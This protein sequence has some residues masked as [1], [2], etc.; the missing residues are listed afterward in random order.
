M[1][2]TSSEW[3]REYDVPNVPNASRMRHKQM[4][5]CGAVT[6]ERSYQTLAFSRKDDILDLSHSKLDARTLRGSRVSCRLS[7]HRR[8]ERL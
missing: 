2:L 1:A 7:R 5:R 6:V 8:T 4:N 3:R